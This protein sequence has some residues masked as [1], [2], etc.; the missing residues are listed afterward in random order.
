[1]APIRMSREE[2]KDTIEDIHS[3]MYVSDLEKALKLADTLLEKCPNNAAALEAKAYVLHDMN[4]N[5][6]ALELLSESIAR[7]PFSNFEKYVLRGQLLS[8]EQAMNDY[9]KAV[10][11]LKAE[12]TKQ[13]AKKDLSEESCKDNSIETEDSDEDNWEDISEKNFERLLSKVYC[14]IACHIMMKNT[15]TDEDFT[16]NE[17]LVKALQDAKETDPTNPETYGLLSQYHFMLNDAAQAKAVLEAS[18]PIWSPDNSDNYEDVELD[19]QKQICEALISSKLF[20]EAENYID[21]L[22]EEEPFHLNLLKAKLIYH[23][24][25]KSVMGVAKSHVLDALNDE[26]VEDSI[27]DEA[28]DLLE[29]INTILGKEP[30]DGLDDAESDEEEESDDEAIGAELEHELLQRAAEEEMDED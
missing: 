17:E 27:M 6:K 10:E 25:I 2:I 26:E 13:K 16:P 15:S 14:Q 1:M 20:A 24:G 11:I 29:N 22:F 9:L 28:Y 19:I 3:L 4:E 23:K 8:G 12:I 5:E 7:E 30:Q 18:K 21:V